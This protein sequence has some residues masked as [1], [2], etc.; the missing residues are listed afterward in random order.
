MAVFVTTLSA[1]CSVSDEIINVIDNAG[2]RTT[3][4]WRAVIENEVL[5]I[6]SGVVE[7]LA[8]TV[9][10]GADDTDPAFHPAG[11]ILTGVAV[12]QAATSEPL[13]EDDVTPADVLTDDTETDV[14]TSDP[15]ITGV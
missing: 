11:A 14:L 2:A 6:R 4:P 5:Y 12:G 9:S 1:D 3:Y 13:V 7:G 8:W 10:R 15:T